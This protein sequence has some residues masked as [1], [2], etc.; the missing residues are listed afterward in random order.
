MK[1]LLLSFIILLFATNS[2]GK[3]G[4][5]GSVQPLSLLK[6]KA[7][8]GL[9]ANAGISIKNNVIYT[10]IG[11]SRAGS[12]Q[13]NQFE[14]NTSVIFGKFNLG[15]AYFYPISKKS[16][17]KVGVDLGFSTLTYLKSKFEGTKQIEY[18]SIIGADEFT[19]NKELIC[20][21]TYN[22]YKKLHVGVDLGLNINKYYT[23]DYKDGDYFEVNGSKFFGPNLGGG[24]NIYKAIP[25]LQVGLIIK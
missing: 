13:S 3:I 2:F 18:N 23:I 8:I 19:L 25:Y 9:V 12:M 6:Y 14:N 16:N 10:S 5:Y 17:I 11:Y 4:F 22:I 15:Y 21:Y 20:G 1:N 7:T 24:K